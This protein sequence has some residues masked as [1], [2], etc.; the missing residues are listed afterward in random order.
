MV[1]RRKFVR[2]IAGDA[3]PVLN[4][5]ELLGVGEGRIDGES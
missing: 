4:A 2:G 5:R 1:V 3:L